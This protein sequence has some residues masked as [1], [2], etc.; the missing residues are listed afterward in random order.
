MTIVPFV[1]TDTTGSTPYSILVPRR[2]ITGG[3]LVTW[4]PTAAD[5]EGISK[6]AYMLAMNPDDQSASPQLI[7]AYQV[8]VLANQ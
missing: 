7:K 1:H 4:D 3:E 6:D 8:V 5:L 2:D